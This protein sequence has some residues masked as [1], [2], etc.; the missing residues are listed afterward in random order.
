MTTR[1]TIRY[2]VTVSLGIVF[3]SNVFADVPPLLEAKGKQ[4]QC[5]SLEAWTRKAQELGG[6]DI[7]GG[8]IMSDFFFIRIR[9][10]FGDSIFEP[11]IGKTYRDLSD[12]EKKKIYKIVDRCLT[13]AGTRGFLPVPFATSA[14]AKKTQGIVIW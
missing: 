1:T 4:Q 13:Q 9:P 7:I 12:K 11:L 3:A 8:N 2:F 5:D 6:D 10:A 14:S